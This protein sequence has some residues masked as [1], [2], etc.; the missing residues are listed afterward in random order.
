MV[1]AW[2][3][4]KRV[5]TYLGTKELPPQDMLPG[6]TARKVG[7]SSYAD[8]LP[9][10]VPPV[11]AGTELIGLKNVRYTWTMP[12]PADAAD[13][14]QTAPFQLHV[15]DFSLSANELVVLWGPVASGKSSLLQVCGGAAATY[16]V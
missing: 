9:R 15:E 12:S 11:A 5:E 7:N 13:N 6:P 4:L 3:S 1:E 14:S 8:V 10:P 2:V 16:S